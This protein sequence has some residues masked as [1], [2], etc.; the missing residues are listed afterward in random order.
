MLER[1]DFLIFTILRPLL[2][3]I[4]SLFLLAKTTRDFSQYEKY[5]F[6]YENLS[7]LNRNPVF[8]FLL[9]GSFVLVD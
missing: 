4:I 8:S 1:P 9:S 5:P 6:E 7:S 3:Y 2:E